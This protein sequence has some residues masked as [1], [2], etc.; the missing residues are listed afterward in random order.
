M[1]TLDFGA[2]RQAAR[3]SRV[4][5]RGPRHQTLPCVGVLVS[6]QRRDLFTMR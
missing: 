5:P 3:M 6:T 1:R 2:S 4:R